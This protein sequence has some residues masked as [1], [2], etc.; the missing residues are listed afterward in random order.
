[1]HQTQVVLAVS[2][3]H[4]HATLLDNLEDAGAF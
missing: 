2:V 4:P 1:M 3:L